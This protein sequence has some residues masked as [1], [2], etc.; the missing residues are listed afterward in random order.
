MA[1][2]LRNS[3]RP[4]DSAALPENA[5]VRARAAD[6]DVLLVRERGRVCALVH[7]CGG[8]LSE[9]ALKDGWSSVR[10]MHPSLRSTMAASWMVR[11]RTTSRASLCASATAV[12]KSKS[13]HGR[14]TPLRKHE[15]HAL[16]P[17]VMS[18][19]ASR[20]AS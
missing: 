14:A 2:S 3:H 4:L 17:K 8:R 18:Q 9:G 15:A 7:A 5:M 13:R 12:S 6:T 19:K 1:H 20:G 11:R 16:E 10:G